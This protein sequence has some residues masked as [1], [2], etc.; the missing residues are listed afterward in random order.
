MR[1][2][3]VKLFFII[4]TTCFLFLLHSSLI[5][6]ARKD[7]DLSQKYEK[8]EVRI[9]MRDGIHLKTYIYTPKEFREHSPFLMLRTP[10][11]ADDYGQK[12]FQIYPEL[13]SEGYIFVIQDI[14]GRFYFNLT[15][16]I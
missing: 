1:R 2:L 12:L 7:Q 5:T 15:L 8:M 10:Y 9:P 14:R 13:A 4:V 16:K 6:S 11:G 3:Y